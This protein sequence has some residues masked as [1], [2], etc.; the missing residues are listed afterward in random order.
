MIKIILYT[1][2]KYQVLYA[3]R[4]LYKSVLWVLLW[5]LQCC[6]CFA[7]FVRLLISYF[8]VIGCTVISFSAAKLLES[9]NFGSS[10]RSPTK[11][12][13]LLLATK[14]WNPGSC[15]QR[16]G[17]SNPC[18]IVTDGSW[19]CCLCSGHCLEEP[20]HWSAQQRTHWYFY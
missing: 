14:Y 4:R 7:L 10:C 6:C 15:P 17:A 19:P 9:W 13:S 18:W 3:S 20:S 16:K 11:P 8:D 12:G 1:S 5:E 2:V